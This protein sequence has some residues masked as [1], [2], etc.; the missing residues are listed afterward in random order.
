MND[1]DYKTATDE[2]IIMKRPVGRP[3]G[4]KDSKPRGTPA[5][6]KNFGQENVEPGDNSRYLGHALVIAR[7]PLIDLNNINEVRER[8]DWYFDYCF[9]SDI[10]PTV[11]GFCSALKISRNTLMLWRRGR[12]RDES[13]QAVILEAY[14]IMEELWEHYMQN[15]K[16]NPVSGI[17]L[18]KN[19]FSYRD[20]QEMVVTPNTATTIEAVDQ[21]LI[22][23]KYAE[24]PPVDDEE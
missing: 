22:E 3:P 5:N 2:P 11:A 20:Q 14:G 6:M 23:A 17:F 8:I 12:Y 9:Q 19:N 7:Q 10:K 15:G 16:I 4:R 24:L 13:Y 21:N 18:A 1:Y